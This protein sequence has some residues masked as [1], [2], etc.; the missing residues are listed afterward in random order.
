MRDNPHFERLADWETARARLDFALAV[1]GDTLGHALVSLSL[2]VRDHRMRGVRAEKQTLEAH[3]GAFNFSLSRPGVEAARLAVVETSYGATSRTERVKD[4][5]ARVYPMGPEPEPDD[6][7]G[8]M[9]AV[10]VWAD[11]DRFYF[12]A[13]HDLDEEALLVIARSVG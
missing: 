11:E 13:S 4:C 8:R 5:E 2:Y 9:P 7:D 1:P 10:V 3:Y 12:L 6:P